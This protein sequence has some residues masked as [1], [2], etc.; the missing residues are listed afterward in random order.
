MFS[1]RSILAATLVCG[2]AFAVNAQTPGAGQ[3]QF[4]AAAFKAAQGAGKPIVVEVHADWC[5]VCAKQKPISAS[6]RAKPDFK[7]AAFFVVDFD[8]QADALK[9]LKVTNQSTI[10]TF[11]G[12]TETSRTTGVSDPKRIE[13]QFRKAL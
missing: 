13:D 11:K 1:R 12:A 4:S 7:N 8:K 5:G 6:L 9:M 3:S 2:A 10:I